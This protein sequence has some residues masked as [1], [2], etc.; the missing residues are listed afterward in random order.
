MAEP[1]PNRPL[2]DLARF[3]LV[4]LLLLGGI[5]AGLIA[6]GVIP[7]VS[8]P[9]RDGVID[10]LILGSVGVVITGIDDVEL[11]SE[12]GRVTVAIAAG[13][14]SSPVLL[15]YQELDPSGNIILARGYP[16]TGRFFELSAQPEV[17]ADGPVTFLPMLAIIVAIGSVDL[18][19]AGNDYSRFALQHYLEQ[20]GTWDVLE[21]IANPSNSTV[22]AHVSSLS[23][24]ALTIG[25]AAI[26]DVVLTPARLE[27]A[28]PEAKTPPPSP[29]LLP[30]LSPASPPATA[31]LPVLPPATAL[32]TPTP[33][34]SPTPAAT[35]AGGPA[36]V[37]GSALTPIPTPTPISTRTP[38][39]TPTLTPISTPTLRPTAAPTLTPTLTPKPT[40]VPT[41]TPTPTPIP[42]AVPTPTPTPTP[43]LRRPQ[44]QRRYTNGGTYAD[45]YTNADPNAYTNGGTYADADIHADIHADSDGCAYS[46]SYANAHT[47][48]WRPHSFPVRPNREFRDH[49]HGSGWAQSGESHKWSSLRLGSLVVRERCSGLCLWPGWQS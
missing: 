19:L 10:A 9:A 8:S 24:F 42:T 35:V 37:P 26:G 3:A 41:P 25:P 14:V 15:R 49:D 40:V 12:N 45:A 46:R 30:V 4:P 16:S 38:T 2:A 7:L 20:Q 29:N 21:T 11:V 27:A 6:S 36:A 28:P 5:L 47:R 44:H 43:T 1:T 31:S 48:S 32:P 17:A 23:R 34:P 39:R 18:V 13:S 33:V 22:T